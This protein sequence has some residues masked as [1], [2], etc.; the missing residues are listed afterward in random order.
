MLG[1]EGARVSR[2]NTIK[3]RSGSAPGLCNPGRIVRELPDP[4]DRDEQCYEGGATGGSMNA[5]GR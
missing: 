4:E 5:M 2:E 3:A 1:S